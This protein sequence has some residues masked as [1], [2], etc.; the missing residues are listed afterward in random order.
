MMVPRLRS[1]AVIACLAFGLPAQDEPRKAWWATDVD[2]A[3]AKTGENRGDILKALRTAPAGHREEVAFLVANMPPGDLRSMR[4]DYLLSN[5]ELANS[6]LAAAPWGK[7]IPRAISL[8]DVLPYVNDTREDWRKD[9]YAHHLLSFDVEPKKTYVIGV[10][11]GGRTK[12]VEHRTDGAKEKLVD[13][14][15]AIKKK[16]VKT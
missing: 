2:A 9:F 8:H 16:T 13:I 3:L 5:V 11:A 4:I 10:T 1:F 15:L 7:K 6:A 14:T 12:E